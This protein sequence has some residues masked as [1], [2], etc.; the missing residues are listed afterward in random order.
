MLE[1]MKIF[2]VNEGQKFV[3]RGDFNV[4]HVH[5]VS[6]LTRNKSKELLKG[7]L[8]LKCAALSTGNPIY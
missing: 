6:R 3:I 1:N 4:K 5:R 8:L 7:R 2:L